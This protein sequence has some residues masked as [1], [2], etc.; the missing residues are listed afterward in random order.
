MPGRSTPEVL[1]HWSKLI[2][3]LNASPLAFYESVER[4]LEARELPDTKRSRVDWHE[5][6]AMSAKREYLRVE[7]G[8]YLFDICGAPYGKGF[9]VSWWLGR[10]VSPY[11]PLVLFG[12]VVGVFLFLAFLVGVFGLGYGFLAWL[13]LTPPGLWILGTL[14]GT[15]AEGWDDPIAAMPLLGKLYV[16]LFH[17]ETYYRTDT[18]LMFQAAVGSAVQEVIEGMTKAAVLAPMS[19]EEWKPLLDRV[20]GP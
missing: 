16:R 18:R 5:G 14:A 17:P 13:L 15:Q 3:G 4:A 7:R 1:S 11:G 20:F 19:P 10:V 9:F 8:R 2:E 6:G 12:L